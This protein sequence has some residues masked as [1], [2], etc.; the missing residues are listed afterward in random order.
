[1]ENSTTTIEWYENQIREDGCFCMRSMQ[2]APGYVQK[3][4]WTEKEF[5]QNLTYIQLRKDNK[6]AGFIEYASGEQAWRAV[7]ADGYLVIIV[8]GLL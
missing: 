3:M 6:P 5:T 2:K 4:N 8:S 7:H 1:M